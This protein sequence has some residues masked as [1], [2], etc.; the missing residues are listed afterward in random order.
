VIFGV[1]L[2]ELFGFALKVV[3][4]CGGMA[5]VEKRHDSGEKSVL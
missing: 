2:S 3:R 5:P 4:F 1:N